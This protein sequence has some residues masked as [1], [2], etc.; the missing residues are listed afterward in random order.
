ME[1]KY[2]LMSD[3]TGKGGIGMK[4]MFAEAAARCRENLNKDL[5]EIKDLPKDV[6][7]AKRVGK[8]VYYYKKKESWEQGTSRY[9]YLG[10]SKNVDRRYLNDI[11]RREILS[12]RIMEAENNLALIDGILPKLVFCDYD[13]LY[14]NLKN[15]GFAGRD[16][17]DNNFSRIAVKY[18]GRE[19]EALE[20]MEKDIAVNSMRPDELIHIT[21]NGLKVRSKSE[22]LIASALEERNLAFKYEPVYKTVDGHTLRPDFAIL[23]PADMKVVYWEHFGLMGNEVYAAR[24]SDKIQRYQNNGCFLWDNLIISFDSKEGHFNMGVINRIINTFLC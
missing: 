5:E 11:L 7:I 19:K 23:R 4:E 13:K 1:T 10:N 3:I 8:Q 17:A 18:K 6:L 9:K 15:R 2:E 16:D 20:W 22:L 24:T 14:R 12:A 21:G